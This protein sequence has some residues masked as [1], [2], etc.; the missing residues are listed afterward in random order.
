MEPQEGAQP[1][2]PEAVIAQWEQPT[3]VG[4]LSGRGG[5]GKIWIIA[6][7]VA[8]LLIA[9]A[10]WQRELNLGLAG[11]VMLLAAL[12]LQTQRRAQALP[13]T[14]TTQRIIIG[15]RDYPISNLAGFW[16]ADQGDVVEVNLE[17]T[18][19]GLLPMTFLYATPSLDEARDVLT[20]VLPELEPREKKLGDKVNGYFKL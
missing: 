2:G 4:M 5:L 16:L 18:K 15:K 13:V 9:A 14:L 6:V 1:A 8:A 10:I 7:V 20:Q 19:P 17:N 11:G 12:A 3:P